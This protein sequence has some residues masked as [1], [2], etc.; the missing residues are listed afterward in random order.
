MGMGLITPVWCGR[1]HHQQDVANHAQTA[2]QQSKH[3]SD[4]DGFEAGVVSHQC[5]CQAEAGTAPGL[6]FTTAF[7]EFKILPVSQMKVQRL[8][9]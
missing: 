5:R 8:G 7:N 1:W 9:G 3:R 2:H 6:I 4:E